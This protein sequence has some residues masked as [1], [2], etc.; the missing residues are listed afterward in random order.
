MADG[1]FMY[2]KKRTS[3]NKVLRD[4]HLILLKIQNM[5][6]IKE[7]LLIYFINPLIKI[8]LVGALKIEIFLI[9][10]LAEKWCKSIIR[11]FSKRKL[12]SVFIDSIWDANSENMHLV[13]GLNKGFRFLL[14]VFDIYIKYT[15]VIL[16]KDKKDITINNA[17]QKILE[18][19]NHGSE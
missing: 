13:S 19:S 14:C 11:M 5:M 15:W 4:K 12:H 2:L 3:A 18:E 7:V 8:L 1:D 10:K 16:L 9:K 17:F 6:D